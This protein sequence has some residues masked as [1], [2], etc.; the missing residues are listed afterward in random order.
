MQTVHGK[1]FNSKILL[2]FC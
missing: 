1:E 2:K